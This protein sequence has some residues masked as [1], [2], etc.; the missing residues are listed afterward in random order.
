MRLIQSSQ[1]MKRLIR[2]IPKP[3]ITVEMAEKPFIMW[4]LV[5]LL[6]CIIVFG[7]SRNRS[8]FEG[9]KKIKWPF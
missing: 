6:L 3:Y 4:L 2:L 1:D 7:C 8:Q 5:M 9:G